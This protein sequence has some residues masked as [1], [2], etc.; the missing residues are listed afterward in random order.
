MK[1]SLNELK[2]YVDIKIETPELIKLIGSR[3]VEI[4]EVIDLSEKY[5][6]IKIIKVAECEK[7]SGTHLSLCQIDA[8]EED[9]IQVVCGAPNVHRGMLAVWLAPGVIV[10]STFGNENFKLGA[11]KLRGFDSNGMLAAADEL[12]FWPD[13]EG[14][15]EINPKDA[16]PGDD[17]AKVFGLDDLIL[18]IENKSLTH[19][20]DCFGL[21][22]F[23][24]EVAGILGQKFVE[25]DFLFHEEVFPKGF[26]VEKD[27]QI[28]SKNSQI[29][30]KIEDKE[31]CPRYS[32]AVLD[33]ES[34]PEPTKY[35]K[36]SDIFL[37][38]A[39]MR[40]VSPIVDLTNVLML[41][42]GQPL[43][44]FDYDKFIAVGKTKSPS[45]VVRLAKDG[46]ELKLLDGKTIKCVPTDI[47][48]T[49]NNLPVALAGAMGGE[50]T[51]IDASTKKI[52]LESA[53]FSLYNLRK[54]QMTHGIFS[55]AITRFTKGQPAGG[56]FNVLAEMI[57]RLGATPLD[58]ADNWA[59]GPQ[60]N[61]V[62]I[63]TKEINSILGSKYSTLEI[64]TTLE[65]V[66]FT[67]KVKDDELT[68]F[69]PTH[70]TDIHIK[71]DIAEEVGRLLGY[72]NLP[73]T[74]PTRDFVG[75]EIDPMLKLKT[76]LRGILSDQLNF[77]ELLTYSFVSRDL[78]EKVN[79]D[80]DDAY[81]IVNSISPEL[82]FF[83]QSIVPSLLD[84]IR[85]NL[86]SGY[87][88]FSFYEINQITKKSLGFD[89]DKTPITE[90]H[91]GLTVFG[92]FYAAKS[93]LLFVLKELGLSAKLKPLASH[94][95]FEPLHSACLVLDGEEVAIFGEIKR[96]ILKKF[97]LEDE[98]SA[99]E[100][101]LEKIVSLKNAKK[102]IP[103]FSKFPFV[104]R[105]L[106]LKVS[107]KVAFEKVENLI[108]SALE[109]KSLLFTLTPASIY[110]P[111][112]SS[113]KNLSFHISFS[114]QKKTLN[115][116]EIS[117]II[118]A[119]TNKLSAELGAEVV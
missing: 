20:P 37:L 93:A 89:K 45:V 80:I 102:S 91:L 52:I 34:L 92:D 61:V 119:I 53:T 28:S 94:A 87:S 90:T 5:K 86:K 14:I 55:E 96:G 16:K 32:C 112:N 66:S 57:K 101:N 67:V 39:G 85:D 88:D 60:A 44:A 46:E 51:E 81:E 38:K 111:E 98:I 109:E 13:H 18:D 75:A 70:R 6:N 8:G 49:S 43:H 63:T 105:D 103:A 9:L 56:T 25:P 84:K 110:K 108:R 77:N 76:T 29:S 12:D 104:S 115:S 65:N 97:K 106:T 19:R 72:D 41:E 40:P 74:F 59:T 79:E 113:L 54:T 21:I 50:N 17:F 47:L 71:E 73:I 64:K 114:D 118:N 7:I 116:E 33:A 27:G 82:Q 58:F 36:K 100:F 10:P 26:L 83:R 48:I 107:E 30:I 95:Y 4:E 31:I 1:I 23:A 117:A 99:V 35:L 11:K 62:K 42:T 22:G 78:M 2:K 69:A 15:L 68:I 24:R 3:L